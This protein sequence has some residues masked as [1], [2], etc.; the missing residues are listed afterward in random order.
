LAQ[1]GFVDVAVAEVGAQLRFLR[2]GYLGG[3]G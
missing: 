2:Y 3:E 1:L